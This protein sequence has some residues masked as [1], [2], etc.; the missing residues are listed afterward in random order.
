MKK[1]LSTVILS[2]LCLLSSLIAQNSGERIFKDVQ[3]IEFR[4]Q[5]KQTNYMELLY[6][7]HEDGKYFP[8]NVEID[9]SSYDSV[10]VRF[11]GTSSFY[12]YPGDKKSLRIKFDKYGDLYF[13]GL[14]K[15]NLNN[16][17]S[18]PSLLRE[19]LYLDFL[20]EHKIPAPRANFARVYLNEVYWGLYSMVEHVDKTFLD[21]R[22]NENDGNLYKAEKLADLSWQGSEQENY[23]DNYTLK[24]NEKINDWDD[25]L[26]LIDKVN[27]SSDEA[28]STALESVLQ[29]QPFIQIWAANNL[30]MN[31][32]DYVGSANNFYLYKHQAKDLFE[33]IIW[34][35]NLAFGSRTNK[36]T[37]NIFYNPDRRPLVTRMLKEKFYRDLYLKTMQELADDF[38]EHYFFEKIDS[39]AAFIAS[40]YL[41]DTLKMY[42]NEE[43]I[44]NL[45]YSV[46]NIPG[47]KTFIS[48]RKH[49]VLS[50]LDSVITLLGQPSSLLPE[51]AKLL[52]NYPNPFNPTSQITY[53][54]YQA[55][56]VE[57]RLNNILG[58]LVRSHH[59][60]YQFQ[61]EHYFQLEADGLPSGV[62][63]YQINSGTFSYEKK[64]LIMK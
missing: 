47:L 53:I 6:K 56:E 50:Q 19:K 60:G 52:Q 2:T 57:F 13:D 39:L 49:D 4:F 27:H 45:D 12:G 36:D 11:K 64:C 23:Y 63:Y 3:I 38:H 8:C 26:Q 33:W 42:S 37:L 31:L 9:G 51:K 29:T 43:I 24:T 44:Q 16:G 59:L 17:W 34:D 5:F 61:G 41:A 54:L 1:T 14:K 58:Q 25:L 21:N 35:V 10:G 40:D 62:Y 7:S 15:I 46:G 30:F 28:F 22:F 18:D 20:Y 55:A 48:N 32:D